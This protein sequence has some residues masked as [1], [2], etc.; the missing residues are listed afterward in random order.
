MQPT[1]KEKLNRPGRTA[2][3][4]LVVEDVPDV[5]LTFAALIRACGHRTQVAYNA[6][7]ALRI[8]TEFRPQTIFIDI[9]LPDTNGFELAK[10]LGAMD[11]LKH[12]R[13]IAISGREIDE[14]EAD[15]AGFDLH[16]RKPIRMESL[17]DI[18]GC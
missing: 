10:Q 18:L 11:S 2:M 14:Q 3:G 7:D 5:A 16:L 9:G 12:T 8:A 6:T 17:L 15:A 13:L 4:V 1:L